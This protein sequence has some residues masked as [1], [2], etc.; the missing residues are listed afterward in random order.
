MGDRCSR[1]VGLG[2]VDSDLR[3]RGSGPADR[4]LRF[5]ALKTRL[6]VVAMAAMSTSTFTAAAGQ[7][8]APAPDRAQ[9]EALARR[10]AQR[11]A[12]LHREAD[13]L[14]AQERTVL[15]DL[16]RLEV[17]RQ[18]RQEELKKANAEAASTSA[19]LGDLGAKIRDLEQ[20]QATE[21]PGLESRLVDVYKLG[22]GGYLRLLLSVDD[23]RSV[24]RA[25]RTVAAL[26]QLDRQRVV[27]HRSTLEALRASQKS[28][29]ERR[30]ALAA[31]QAEA[32]RARAAADRAAAARADLIAQIDKRRDLNAELAGEL[33]AA[34]Q[35]LQ[36]AV[37]SMTAGK[38]PAEPVALPVRPFQGDLDWP[39]AGPVVQRF[40]RYASAAGPN[41]IE[42]A[43]AEGT[44]VSAIHDGTV[45]YADIF[46][47]FGNLVI[48]DHGNQAF[49]LYG[50]L[51]SVEVSRGARVARGQ[52][53]GKAGAA[54]AG[55]TGVYFELRIDGKPVDPVQWLRKR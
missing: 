38:A 46:A 16:Q 30:T 14:A 19:Q 47:G 55:P 5:V 52:P 37:A 31:I 53:V 42:I 27:E 15:V 20:R 25:Y 28:L 4:R 3:T 1:D 6:L 54:P 2:A 7:P 41:G 39:L 49:S 18:L 33:Q 50:H 34:Q 24:G 17:E 9:A 35:K 21:R 10:A 36:Q 51:S 43:S 12:A 40:G 29:Q 48:V 26:S 45:A 32:Q 11:I 13:A 23:M 22:R 44:T 8:P